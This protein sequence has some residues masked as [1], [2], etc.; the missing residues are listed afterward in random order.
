MLVSEVKVKVEQ[1]VKFTYIAI[2]FHLIVT[3][4][5]NLVHILAY[6]KLH[7]TDLDLDF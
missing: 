7:Q 4:T 1:K 3:E 6:E 5:S 2:T